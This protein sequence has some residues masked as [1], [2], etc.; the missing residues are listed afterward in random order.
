MRDHDY[1][2]EAIDN[3]VENLDGEQECVGEI[4]A[5]ELTHQ[6]LALALAHFVG[7]GVEVGPDRR[8]TEMIL[9]R[10]VTNLLE[11]IFEGWAEEIKEEERR[12][13]RLYADASRADQII[14]DRKE[15]A[16]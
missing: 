16:A 2:E 8:R 15:M 10:K 1:V 12:T 13:D 7:L 3:F 5:E 9:E 11:G 4:L 14:K 6:E